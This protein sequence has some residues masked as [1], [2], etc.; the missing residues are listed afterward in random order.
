MAEHSIRRTIQSKAYTHQGIGM[1]QAECTCGA[2][3]GYFITEKKAAYSG[4]QHVNHLN[5]LEKKK[6]K[7]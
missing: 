1:W 2:K 6:G 5:R 4:I 3:T 7:K